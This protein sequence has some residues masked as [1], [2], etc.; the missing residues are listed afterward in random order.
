MQMSSLLQDLVP[1]FDHSRGNFFPLYLARISPVLTCLCCPFSCPSAPLTRAW[2]V[3]QPWPPQQPYWACSCMPLP[4]C[5]E[6]QTGCLAPSPTGQDLSLHTASCT[7]A[8][9]VGTRSALAAGMH[10]WLLGNLLS[11]W[12]PTSQSAFFCKAAYSAV[13]SQPVPLHGVIPAQTQAFAQAF[14]ELP[15]SPLSSFLQ[16][17]LV[18]LNGGCSLRCIHYYAQ[19]GS[20]HTFAGDVLHSITQATSM[21]LNSTGLKADPRGTPLTTRHQFEFSSPN[22][23]PFTLSHTSPAHL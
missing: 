14:T 15:G 20:V 21:M 7:P 9:T 12:T 17:T 13:S 2:P 22:H 18:P 3:L 8:L 19:F 16:P 1:Q 23:F 11:L 5:W 6:A 10:H 4:S